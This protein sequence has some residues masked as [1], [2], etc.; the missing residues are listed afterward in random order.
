MVNRKISKILGPILGVMGFMLAIGVMEAPAS[1]EETAQVNSTASST[2]TTTTTS[3][4]VTLKDYSVNINKS[5]TQNGLTVTVDKAVATKHNL[6]VILKIQSDKPFE[7]NK[8]NDSIFE[9]TYGNSDDFGA[10]SSESYIDDKTMILTLEKDSHK[11]EYPKSGDLR[12]DVAFPSYKANIG[13]DIPVDFTESFNNVIEK[14]LSIKIPE[15]IYTL[16][17]LE[18]TVL[19]TTINYTKPRSNNDNDS[20][21]HQSLFNSSIILKVGDK[22]Y[23][24]RSRGGY[25]G[26]DKEITGTY[27]AKSVTYDKIKD[28]KNISIIP[29]ICNISRDEL[30]KFYS[31]NRNKKD[32]TNKETASN[33]HYEKIFNFSDGSKG[34]IYNIERTD[35]SIKVYCKGESEKESLLMASNMSMHYKYVKDSNDNVFFDNNSNMSFYKDSKESLG[36]VIEFNN[37]IKDKEVD[38]N[39]TPLMKQVD[40]YKLSDEVKLPN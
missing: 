7:K 3:A 37:V 24:A 12:V 14:D 17:K 25:S 29:L 18:S 10:S 20:D 31:E 28:E 9:V 26:D 2:V 13:M 21:D 19:G 15:F 8:Y 11:D 22:M 38:L 16:N 4:A 6:K 36:Y 40:K 27:E 34:E 23:K 30:D 1:A 32:T 39:F 5:E 35:N 33:V